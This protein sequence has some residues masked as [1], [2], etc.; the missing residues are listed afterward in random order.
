MLLST[1]EVSTITPEIIGVILNINVGISLSMS[2]SWNF[3][4]MNSQATLKMCVL[5]FIQSV[6]HDNS[7]MCVH[8]NTPSSSFFDEIIRS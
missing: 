5:V 1:E 2:L 4:S 7:I 6:S 3:F 8:F